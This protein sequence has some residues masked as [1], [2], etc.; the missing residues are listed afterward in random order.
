MTESAKAIDLETS[1]ANLKLERDAIVLYERLAQLE[2]DSGRRAAFETI[3]RNERRHAA[4]WQRRL[5]EVGVT[6]PPFGGPRPRVRLILLLAR[7][8]GTRYVSDMVTALEGDEQELYSAQEDPEVA[9][10]IDDEREHAEIWRRLKFQAAAGTT[11]DD[12]ADGAAPAGSAASATPAGSSA[13]SGGPASPAAAAATSSLGDAAS[14][15][16]AAAA[17]LTEQRITA[18][19]DLDRPDL[20]DPG[21]TER[22]HRRGQSGTLRATIFGV[23]DG[24]VSNLSLVMGVVGAGADNRIIVL[25]GLAGLIAGSISMAAGEWISMKSQKE[26]FERQLQ[27]EREEMRIMP[28]EEEFELAAVYHRRG[29]ATAQALELAHRL[30]ADP[31]VALDTKAREELG[32]DPDELGSPWGAAAGSLVSFAAGAFVPLLPFLVLTGMAAFVG[33]VALSALALFLVGAA[34][35]LVTGRGLVFSGLRQ[36]LIGAFAATVTF[37]VGLVVGTSAS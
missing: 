34:V 29:I 13:A 11:L 32:L 7:L 27:L 25:A 3:A 31:E 2:K 9:G 36:V 17:T 5:E 10:I 18:G 19:P 20:R 12:G 15:I 8:F 37:S 30:M 28:K 16:A 6:V 33:A 35:S 22:W 21:V 24:L 14:E 26:L 23:S 4:V 1:V